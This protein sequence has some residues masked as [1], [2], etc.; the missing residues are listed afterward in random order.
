MV[1]KYLQ[2]GSTDILASI[3]Q[4][5][6]RG[7]SNSSPSPAHK[8]EQT[9]LPLVTTTKKAGIATAAS[10]IELCSKYM[11]PSDLEKIK[12]AYRY[13][14]D[15]HLGQFRKSGEP[16][17][18]HPISV[19]CILAEWHLDC[20]AIQAGLMHDVLEDTG[21]SKNEMAKFSIS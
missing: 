9:E 19:A 21:H 6:L 10:L 15:A 1:P 7:E 5:I 14:D 13:A 2:T 3:R 20:A 12:E 8:E 16:Y 17:I 11:S 18:T 4:S